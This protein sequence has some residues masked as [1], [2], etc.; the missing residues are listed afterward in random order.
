MM[1]LRTCLASALAVLALSGTSRSASPE[2]NA[3]AASVPFEI[4]RGHVMIQAQ[5]N[6]TDPHS[7]MLDTGYGVTLLPPGQADALSLRR[8]GRITIV[9]IAGEE[10]AG[11]FEGPEFDFGGLRWKPRRVAAF[12]TDDSSRRSRHGI[13]GSGFFRKYVVEID[14]RTK[15]VILRLPENFRYDGDG[16]VVPLAFKDSTPIVEANFIEAS[17]ELTAARFELDLGCDSALC[18]GRDYAE[19]HRLLP[20][21]ARSS[22]S[23]SGV[24]GSTRTH[25][26]RSPDL[27]IGKLT[28]SKPRAN[29]FLEGSPVDAPLAGHIGYELLRDHRLILDYS[30]SRLIVERAGQGQR[31]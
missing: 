11:M 10:Q 24:G 2:T 9:G 16:E 29:F 21:D 14:P 4:R 30:R 6:D 23:R 22:G 27:R 5:M 15:R 31:D 25:L 12:P 3:I 17:G 1:N 19:K 8:A 7:F 20:S 13:L 28:F 18:L 26:G